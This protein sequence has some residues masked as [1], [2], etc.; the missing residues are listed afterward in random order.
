MAMRRS[1]VEETLHSAATVAAAAFSRLAPSARSLDRPTPKAQAGVTSS[2]VAHSTIS[3]STSPRRPTP[4]SPPPPPLLLPPSKLR[5]PFA[6]K[7]IL[8]TINAGVGQGRVLVLLAMPAPALASLAL[9]SARNPAWTPASAMVCRLV[10]SAAVSAVNAASSSADA[11]K[12]RAAWSCRS[13]TVNRSRNVSVAVVMAPFSAARSGASASACAPASMGAA[14]AITSARASSTSRR[15]RAGSARALLPSRAALAVS[16]ST[17]AAALAS[18]WRMRSYSIP[19]RCT[20]STTVEASTC[21]LGSPPPHVRATAAVSSSPVAESPSPA[22]ASSPSPSTE[23]S[24][25]LPPSST[26]ASDGPAKR[27]LG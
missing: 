3:I 26:A 9:G 19:A 16:T 12:R 23:R 21:P 5:R 4:G 7:L 6:L 20:T 14:M 10:S 22:A 13:C 25:T 11:A 18:T 27:G 17:H 8:L 24:P 1:T 2:D 15:P